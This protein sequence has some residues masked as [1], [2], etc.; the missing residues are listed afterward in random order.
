MTRIYAIMQHR[1]DECTYGYEEIVHLF[2]DK[3]AADYVCESLKEKNYGDV[4]VYEY[5]AIDG[6]NEKLLD[7]I[8]ERIISMKGI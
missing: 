7:T 5:C 2:T 4:F 3:T 6:C 1:G 8:I